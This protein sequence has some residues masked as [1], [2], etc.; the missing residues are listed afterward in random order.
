MR[1]EEINQFLDKLPI[2]IM[3]KK[4]K[5]STIKNIIKL[6]DSSITFKDKFNNMFV[7]DLEDISTIEELD[8]SLE[9]GA[10]KC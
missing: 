4:G 2:K 8:S 6:T 7:I 10:I 1:K 9:G 3:T 5:V